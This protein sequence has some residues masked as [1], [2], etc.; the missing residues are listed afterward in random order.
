MERVILAIAGIV[1]FSS[2]SLAQI[3]ATPVPEPST[4]GLL[5]IGVAG[6]V[7]AVRMRNRK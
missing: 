2:Q 6:V 4:L 7:I 1:L 5:A 3:G